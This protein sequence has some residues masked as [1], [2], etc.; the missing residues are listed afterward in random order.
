MIITTMPM[1]TDNIKTYRLTKRQAAIHL[2]FQLTLPIFLLGLAVYWWRLEVED[3]FM[4]KIP[5][6]VVGFY[7]LYECIAIYTHWK[8]SR[9]MVITYNESTGE[10]IYTKGD[11]SF[12][13]LLTDVAI[14]EHVTSN[15]AF[16]Q[17]GTLDYYVFTINRVHRT[18]TISALL[19]IHEIVKTLKKMDTCTYTDDITPFH[20]IDD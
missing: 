15:T 18:I 1:P 9:D 2:S 4:T 11:D 17:Y 14:L 8:H 10:V 19:S 3:V 5:A 7:G 16:H 20:H 13:F 6:L 12:S